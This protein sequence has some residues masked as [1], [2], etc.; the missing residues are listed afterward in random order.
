MKREAHTMISTSGNIGVARVS[1]LAAE[2]EEACE[3]ADREDSARLV[4]ALSS[5]HDA[6]G[7]AIRAWLDAARPPSSGGSMSQVA[8]SSPDAARSALIA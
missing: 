1:A 3:N 2:L 4:E 8:E 7:P 6:A 5:A